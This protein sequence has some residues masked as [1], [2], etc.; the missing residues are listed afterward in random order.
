MMPFYTDVAIV[1]AGH[2][3]L[4][5]AAYLARAGFRVGVFERRP[6]VGG[7]S[8]TEEVWPGFHFS[9]CAQVT[10]A[11]HPRIARDLRLVERGMTW[12]HRTPGL[13]IWSD[14]TY[15]GPE[16]HDSPRNRAFAGRMTAEERDGLA[17]YLAFKRFLHSCYAHH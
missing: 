16:S 14:G 5:A 12:V 2:N 3:G 9:P 1:G 13:Q 4:V 8:T 6:F 15:V 10:G 11:I 7:A 17:N